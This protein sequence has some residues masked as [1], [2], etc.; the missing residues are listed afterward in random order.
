MLMLSTCWKTLCTLRHCS[1]V[2]PPPASRPPRQRGP[3]RVDM[4]IETGCTLS[5]ARS[6]SV[7]LPLLRNSCS[8]GGLGGI[9]EV[10]RELGSKEMW[11]KASAS[12]GFSRAS[13]IFRHADACVKVRSRPD[14]HTATSRSA[15]CLRVSVMLRSSCA[16]HEAQQ[17]LA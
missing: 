13:A 9:E 6:S 1:Y 17:W 12:S 15:C 3:S 2:R 8:D 4:R 5:S 14:R 7:A 10:E 16:E 11:R